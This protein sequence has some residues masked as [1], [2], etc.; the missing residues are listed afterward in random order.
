MS[1]HGEM[2]DKNVVRVS[3]GSRAGMI[4]AFLCMVMIVWERL[5]R[6][7]NVRQLGLS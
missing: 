5:T 7:I 2:K 1:A 4:I 6:V 3:H